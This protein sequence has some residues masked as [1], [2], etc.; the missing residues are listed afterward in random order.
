MVILY[1]GDHDPSGL[2]MLTDIR[3]RLY[4]FLMSYDDVAYN[5]SWFEEVDEMLA[6]VCENDNTAKPFNFTEKLYR[7]WIHEFFVYGSVQDENADWFGPEL[8]EWMEMWNRDWEFCS[9]FELVH[10]GL[11]MEQIEK[12][13]PPPN[14]AKLT[15]KR[16]AK[17]ILEHGEVSWEVD[18][19]EPSVLTELIQ[20]GIEEYLDED[21]V[22]EIKEEEERQKKM[23]DDFLETWEK[24]SET[25][26]YEEDDSEE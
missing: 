7:Q 24:F 8:E 25:W 20:E 9:K 16:A 3:K 17:Y 23:M 26:E 11:T 10:L 21:R 4:E 12:Y 18:A 5:P 13:G 2:D 15:D 19:L 22:E 1:L 6:S 14:P